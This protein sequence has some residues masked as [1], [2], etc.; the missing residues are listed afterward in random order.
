MPNSINYMPSLKAFLYKR[1][2][3]YCENCRT[4]LNVEG[5][6]R[7]LKRFK[8]KHNPDTLNIKVGD[9]VTLTCTKCNKENIHYK[10]SAYSIGRNRFRTVCTRCLK[11]KSIQL[12][13]KALQINLELGRKKGMANQKLVFVL[14]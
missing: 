2:R 5:N 11:R 14:F 6:A 13:N 9:S 8:D 3:L 7:R 1:E 10:P 4:K 12:F